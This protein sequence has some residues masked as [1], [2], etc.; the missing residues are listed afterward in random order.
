MQKKKSTNGLFHLFC[1]RISINFSN[2]YFFSTFHMRSI[3]NHVQAI[4]YNR[5]IKIDKFASH[6]HVDN[7]ASSFSFAKFL[8]FYSNL[9]F[10]EFHTKYSYKCINFYRNFFL[11]STRDQDLAS[12]VEDVMFDMFK[13]EETGLLHV[14]KFLAVSSFISI[15]FLLFLPCVKMKL[16]CHLR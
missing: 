4:V 8:L 7:L 3:F 11:S 1:F 13:N 14:G 5:I 15:V 6:V 12:N 9:S 16:I 2:A 10:L